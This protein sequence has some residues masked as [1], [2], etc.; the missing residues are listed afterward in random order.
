MWPRI[1][2]ENGYFILFSTKIWSNDKVV[3][4]HKIK[5]FFAWQVEDTKNN[6]I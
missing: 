4:C 6:P 5:I 3:H 2:I 1:L